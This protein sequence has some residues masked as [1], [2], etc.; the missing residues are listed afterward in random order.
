M[1][2][3]GKS[4]IGIRDYAPYGC[5][6][7]GK[8]VIICPLPMRQK[9]RDAMSEHADEERERRSVEHSGQGEAGTHNN[10]RMHGNRYGMQRRVVQE[11]ME[12]LH[13]RR[14]R[15]D[16]SIVRHKAKG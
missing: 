1:L 6:R 2:H 13:K 9:I 14:L 10:K 11:G 16:G 15:Y 7:D 3:D 4:H 5:E 12:N 8:K